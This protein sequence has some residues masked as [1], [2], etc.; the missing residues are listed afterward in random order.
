M[1]TSCNLCV[2]LRALMYQCIN[3]IGR[4]IQ[5]CIISKTVKR[6]TE[7]FFVVS[8]TSVGFW[9]WFLVLDRAPHPDCPMPTRTAGLNITP[10]GMCPITQ[11][12]TVQ[13]STSFTSPSSIDL[14][15]FASLHLSSTLSTL[16]TFSVPSPLSL[17]WLW[18]WFFCSAPCTAART[19]AEVPGTSFHSYSQHK[20]TLAHTSGAVLWF[21]LSA[22]EG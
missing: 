15:F 8:N 7:V 6:C 9:L 10:A 22:H 3:G 16:P 4:N 18:Y 11:I 19:E 14:L 12:I 1:F 2:K 20:H 21:C 13:V 5:L 17:C